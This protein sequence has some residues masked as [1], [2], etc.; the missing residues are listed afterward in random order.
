MYSTVPW[1]CRAV[2]RYVHVPNLFFILG[3]I[4]HTVERLFLAHSSVSAG[5]LPLVFLRLPPFDPEK[6]L[7]AGDVGCVGV[8][9]Q[10]IQP[11]GFACQPARD[12]AGNSTTR[13]TKKS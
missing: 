6:L 13:G 4:R 9:Y 12:P 10:F 5:C 1:Y 7:A 2:D 11:R 8:V 3:K